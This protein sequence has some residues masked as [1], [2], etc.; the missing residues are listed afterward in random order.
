[1]KAGR[2]HRV[3]LSDRAVEILRGLDRFGERVFAIGPIPMPYLLKA[4]RP[5]IT[6]HGFR[7]SFVDWCHEQ[8]AFPKVVI[9]QALAHTVGDRVEGAYR[10]GDLLQK[11]KQLME[12]WARYCSAKPTSISDN[13]V[14]PI[15]ARA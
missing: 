9:D 5:G 7:S 12:A 14:V 13:K 10:R 11:R 8:T 2:E 1:M 3:P 4:M 6:V 15:A